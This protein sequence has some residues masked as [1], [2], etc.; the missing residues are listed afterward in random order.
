MNNLEKGRKQSTDVFVYG[1]NAGLNWES[2]VTCEILDN[3]LM[4][5]YKEQLSV[6]V[7]NSS[8][9]A[10]TLSG[11]MQRYQTRL[12]Q[13]WCYHKVLSSAETRVFTKDFHGMGTLKLSVLVNPD[14]K[15]NR[16]ILVTRTSGM[17]LFTIGNISRLISFSGILE[18]Q[19]KE[20]NEYFR[21]MET[22]AHDKWYREDIRKS[23]S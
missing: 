23:T 12:K 10:K 16:K 22:P 13:A 2:D 18:M 3:F 20:L 5:I 19:G 11:Y 14:E 1:F 8:I 15:L 4:A 9:D 21:E 6:S 7:N 17:K